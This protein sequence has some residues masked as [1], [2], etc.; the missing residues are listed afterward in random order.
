MVLR[1]IPANHCLVRARTQYREDDE[2][3]GPEAEARVKR[4]I[5]ALVDYIESY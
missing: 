3:L 1:L 4:N 5:S 2:K